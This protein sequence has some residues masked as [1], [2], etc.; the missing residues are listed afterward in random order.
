MEAIRDQWLRP[1]VDRIEELSRENGRLEQER[2]TLRAELDLLR[3]AREDAPVAH[4]SGLQSGDVAREASESLI[5]RIRR[6]LGR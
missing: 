2:D 1:L 3:L 5:D 6:L 4:E